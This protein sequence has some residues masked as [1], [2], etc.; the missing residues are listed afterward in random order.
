MLAAQLDVDANPY[1][2]EA[3]TEY[4]YSFGYTI[5]IVIPA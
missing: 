1:H 4:H 2:V 5:V 3:V